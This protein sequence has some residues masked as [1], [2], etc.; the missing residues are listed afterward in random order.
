[1]E[2]KETTAVRES[3]EALRKLATD[4][5]YW[6]SMNPERCANVVVDGVEA[7]LRNY[8]AQ[9]PEELRQ[10][11]EQRYLDLTKQWLHCLSRC[12]SPHVTGPAK[13]NTRR[14]DKANNAERNARQR[15]TEWAERFIKRANRQHRLT[16]WDEIERLTIKVEQL[17]QLQEL[18]KSCNAIVRKKKLTDEEKIDEIVMLG[19]SEQN[20]K[21]ILEPDFC[22]RI[23]FPSYALTNNLAKIK[24]AQG[25]IDNLTKMVNTENREVETD[26][27]TI[28][29]DYQEERI[30]LHFNDIPA[31]ELR[32]QL[33]QNAFK[34]SRMNQAWQRQLTPNA[35]R[36]TKHIFGLTDL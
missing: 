36:A 9:I 1:M 33:K 20:A 22:G 21:K 8:Q 3:V 13:F 23:G 12:A 19:M 11:F 30:R 25:R 17:T 18:M 5:H 29:L 26:W 15:I 10:D 35:L 7:E 31:V 24:Q 32:T 28:E 34:W 2:T 6:I 27:G 14:A 4:A 16:G